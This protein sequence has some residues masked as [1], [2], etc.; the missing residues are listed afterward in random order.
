M[1]ILFIA[2]LPPP[3]HGQSL[4]SD[5]LYQELRR[6]HD[7]RLV[8]MAKPTARHIWDRIGRV[9]AVLSFLGGVARNTGGA[10]VIY[11][12]ISESRLGNLK[13]LCIYVLCA[14]ALDRMFI[15]LLGGAGIKRILERRGVQS[16]LNRFFISR[17]RGVIVEGR[18]Q[19]ATFSNVI[20]R[21]RIHIRH[22]F[23][24]DFLFFTEQ[25]VR[26]KFAVAGTLNVLFLSNLYGGKGHNELVDG[27]LSL[28][29]ELRDRFRVAFVG[30]FESAQLRE[31]FLRKI[32]GE[33]GLS[34][35]GTFIAGNEKRALYG[36]SQVFCL[37]TY[38]PYEGQPISILEAYA[39]GCV[40]ITT[41]HSGIPEVFTDGVN[42]FAVE[43]R[44][45][46]SIRHALERIAR[47][48]QRLVEVAVA[49]RNVAHERYRTGAY[50]SALTGILEGRA[51]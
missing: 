26:D 5:V 7:V 22:N 16:W 4:A 47:D 32:D 42:G 13:D 37:P 38:Y 44:S 24:E 43:T 23:A 31:E 18:M 51:H 30:G 3:T 48:P 8:N 19:A 34:Y 33:A 49:N 36:K 2:P 35:L 45:A 21:D 28:P 41:E 1:R 40:V 15:H 25:E 29:R 50:L 46:G 10:D 6:R 14:G 11:L 9:G 17:M 39:T 20:A 12:T 27:Y